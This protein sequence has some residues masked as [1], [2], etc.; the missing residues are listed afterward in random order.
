MTVSVTA[1]A[2]TVAVS[3]VIVEEEEADNVGDQA[4]GPDRDDQLW[5]RYLC[6]DQERQW[7]VGVESM[8]P[9]LTGVVDEASDRLHPN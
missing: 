3:A 1:G 7:Q 6:D 4:G 2:S 9:R 8:A 5:L